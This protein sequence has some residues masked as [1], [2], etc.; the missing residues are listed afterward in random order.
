MFEKLM[1]REVAFFDYFDRQ[2]AKHRLHLVAENDPCSLAQQANVPIYALTGLLDPIVPWFWVR[3]W[4]KSNCP[5]LREYK[6]IWRADHNVLGTASQAAAEQVVQ[7][8]R[9]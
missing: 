6:I 7:W 8:M 4:L 2:A 3:R 9:R 5:A 1:P